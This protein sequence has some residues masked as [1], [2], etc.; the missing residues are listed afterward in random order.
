M[1]IEDVKQLIAGDEHRA[2]ELKKTTGELKD[3]MHSACAFLNTEGGNI[4][5]HLCKCTFGLCL[6]QYRRGLA[7]IRHRTH[8]A[9]DCRPDGQ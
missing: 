3:G 6:P 4:Y 1:T 8:I 9:E 7:N 2:L 5:T